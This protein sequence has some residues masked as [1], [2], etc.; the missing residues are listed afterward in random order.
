MTP[1]S[2]TPREWA[3][4]GAETVFP[5]SIPPREVTAERL[6][7]LFRDAMAAKVDE[8]RKFMRHSEF[9]SSGVMCTCGL[10]E[11]VQSGGPQESGKPPFYQALSKE[12]HYADAKLKFTPPKEPPLPA[13]DEAE[14]KAKDITYRWHVEQH[15]CLH[16]PHQWHHLDNAI[17]AAIR[18]AG[19]DMTVRCGEC[20]SD[21]IRHDACPNCSFQNCCQQCCAIT[22]LQEDVASKDAAI[23]RL[24]AALGKAEAELERERK[25]ADAAE[26]WPKCEKCKT[27]FQFLSRYAFV[28]DECKTCAL[29]TA[30]DEAI[31][32]LKGMA[33][34][35][36]GPNCLNELSK[37]EARAYNIIIGLFR[38]V[39]AALAVVEKHKANSLTPQAACDTQKD[40]KQ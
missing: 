10:R 25:R 35:H 27:P 21:R 11:L 12:A 39:D 28:L 24:G 34:K 38:D 36:P 14:R 9:C 29:Q 6:E 2:P 18:E 33:S 17:A 32:A 13:A 16:D 3:E 8:C 5:A 30:L 15:V 19:K 20:G 23:Q 22:C 7:P 40:N 1:T 26:N 4:R 37:F 31:Q